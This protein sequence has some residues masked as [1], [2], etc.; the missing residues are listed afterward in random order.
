VKYKNGHIPPKKVKLTHAANDK[1]QPGFVA[2]E[3]LASGMPGFNAA[4]VVMA[5]LHRMNSVVLPHPG[6]N[7]KTEAFH[8][9]KGVKASRIRKQPCFGG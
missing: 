2:S 9:R 7:A 4:D 5:F 3:C 1:G 8:A 6:E